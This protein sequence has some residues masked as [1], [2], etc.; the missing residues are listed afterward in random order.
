[1]M[2]AEAASNS[3]IA[4]NNL[5]ST[6]ELSDK[7]ARVATDTRKAGRRKSSSLVTQ[8]HLAGVSLH[9][10]EEQMKLLKA[11]LREIKN[12]YDNDSVGR[13]KESHRP[14]LLFVVG[15]SG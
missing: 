11:K 4:S 13:C 5:A 3:N 9:G 10:R 2:L 7:V 1:M 6:R 12:S 14:G 8:L 15:E